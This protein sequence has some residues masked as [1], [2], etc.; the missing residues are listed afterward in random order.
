MAGANCATAEKDSRPIEASGTPDSIAW[1]Y[2][3]DTRVI[4]NIEMRRA[5]SR[6]CDR[7]LS[8]PPERTLRSNS[9]ITMSL[10][11][12]IASATVATITMPLAAEKPPRKVSTVSASRSKAIGRAS[13]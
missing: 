9:G 4:A 11:T 8:R 3:R 7:S 6:V 2:S 13:V 1:K 12:M 5:R 10:L